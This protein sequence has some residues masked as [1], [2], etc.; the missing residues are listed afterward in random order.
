MTFFFAK[1]W[2]RLIDPKMSELLQLIAG[3]QWIQRNANQTS[4]KESEI[5]NENAGPSKEAVAGISVSCTRV[6]CVFLGSFYHYGA[7]G[8]VRGTVILIYTHKLN[9]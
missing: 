3:R 2:T 1:V 8:N 7:C 9:S 6:F 5:I 4:L